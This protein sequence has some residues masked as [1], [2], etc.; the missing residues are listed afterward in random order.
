MRQFILFVT[1]VVSTLAQDTP[2]IVFILA[3]DMSFDSVS[4]NNSKMG[5]LK[6]PHIDRLISQGM[7]FSDAHSGSAVCTPTRYGLLTGRY[8]WRS[9]LK[10]SVLW[11]WG[12]PLIEP[13]RLTVAELLQQNGYVTGMVGKWHLGMT[14]HDSEGKPA[15]AHLKL[16]DASFRKASAAR[17]AAAAKQIDFAKAIRGGPVDHGFDYYFGV[18]VPNFPPYAWIRNDRVQ[19]IPSQPKPASM[20]GAPGPMIPGW[21]LE[22]ILV[23]LGNDAADWIAKQREGEKPFFLYLPL[24]SPHLPTAPSKAFQG[25]SG[26]SPYADFVMETDWVVGHVMNALEDAGCA[27]NTLLFFSTDNGTSARG[28]NFKLLE[29]H[30]IDLHHHFKGHKAQIHE[31]GHRVPFVARWPAKIKAGSTCS[32]TICLNDF[33]ATVADVLDTDLPEDAAEDSTSILPLLTGETTGLPKRPSVVNHDIGGR[34]AIRLGKWK[35]VPGKT[36][37]LFDLDADPKES[38]NVASNFPE[39][40]REMAATLETY[41]TSGRSRD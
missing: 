19:G 35:L 39:V 2:N 5:A 6:T 15:N 38:T 40:L 33:M 27:D 37:A 30:G 24:T 18:D 8:C 22:E 14:W 9:R 23:G 20:F 13:E 7:N 34:F 21:K 12:A 3:D 32:E 17:V 29:S 11:S 36:P 31:G 25:K 16:G 28:A 4:A 1:L 26:I 10:S 41:K